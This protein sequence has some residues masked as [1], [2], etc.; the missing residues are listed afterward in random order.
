MRAIRLE[1][2]KEVAPW[3][4]R[5]SELR[6]YMIQNIAKSRD[7]G[8][9]TGAAGQYYRVQIKDKVQAKITDWDAFYG[10]IAET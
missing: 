2:E 9:D 4:S 10:Y 1:M 5:E 6:E 7:E 3:K 8:G